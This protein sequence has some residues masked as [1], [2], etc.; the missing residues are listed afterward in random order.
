LPIL[1]REWDDRGRP[2]LILGYSGAA[3]PTFYGLSYVDLFSTALVNKIRPSTP[4]PPMSD[5]VLVAVGTK[6]LQSHPEVYDW[7]TSHAMT[8][9]RRDG[10]YMAWDVSNDPEAFRWM[11]A[12]YEAMGRDRHRQWVLAAAV[13]SRRGP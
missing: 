9:P 2:T 10:C 13:K 8:L 4:P 12:V 5:R 1:K 3:D 7:L 11:A 6:L